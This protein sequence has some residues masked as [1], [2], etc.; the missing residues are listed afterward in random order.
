MDKP[1]YRAAPLWS[2]SLHVGQIFGLSL[3]APSAQVCHMGC[4]NRRGWYYEIT[5]RRIS[6]YPGDYSALARQTGQRTPWE[7]TTAEMSTPGN[8]PSADQR[9]KCQTSPCRIWSLITRGLVRSSLQMSCKLSF[10]LIQIGHWWRNPGIH[11]DCITCII[12]CSSS[13]GSIR[14]TRRAQ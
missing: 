8:A 9:T 13:H 12:Q 2:L 11:C 3:P 14:E 4:I 6:L 5:P 10:V 1:H 7:G